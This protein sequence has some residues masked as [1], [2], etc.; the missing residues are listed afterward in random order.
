MDQS[1]IWVVVGVQ[2]RAGPE[3]TAKYWAKAEIMPRNATEMKPQTDMGLQPQLQ[4]AIQ[5]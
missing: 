2:D 5:P 3:V 4:P 1:Q